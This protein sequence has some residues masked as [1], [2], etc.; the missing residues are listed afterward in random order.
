METKET[1]TEVQG[2]ADLVAYSLKWRGV[3]AVYRPEGSATP[4]TDF[5]CVVRYQSQH[6][7]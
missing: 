3:D 7:E 1:V 6:M 4:Y 5:L 2:G